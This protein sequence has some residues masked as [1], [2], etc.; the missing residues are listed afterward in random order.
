MFTRCESDMTANEYERPLTGC[1]VDR[2][3]SKELDRPKITT[4][5]SNTYSPTSRYVRRRSRTS[6]FGTW[7]NAG[8]RPVERLIPARN[9]LSRMASTPR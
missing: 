4:A 3:R 1:H 8:V 5:K 2:L 7:D 9:A 6:L